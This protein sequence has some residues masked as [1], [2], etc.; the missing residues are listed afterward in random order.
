MNNYIYAR[1]SEILLYDQF[2]HIIAIPLNNIFKS[3]LKDEYLNQ[4]LVYLYLEKKK[5]KKNLFTYFLDDPFS[6]KQLSHI[7]QKN[8]A[9]QQ[10]MIG[11]V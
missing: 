1:C 4:L 3:N 5:K 2:S 7:I 6:P 10:K 9:T 8:H 11:L